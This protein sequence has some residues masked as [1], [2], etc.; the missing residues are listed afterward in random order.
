MRLDLRNGFSYVACCILLAAALAGASRAT[1]EKPE[2]RRLPIREYRDKMKAGWIGQIIGVSWGAP[3]EGRYQQIMPAEKMPPFREELVNDAFGQDDLYVE[4]TFLRSLQ[5]YGLDVSI[6]Q[7]GIDFAN[8]GYPLWVANDAGRRNLRNGIAPPDSSHPKFHNCAG[9]ID[10]QIESDY[11]GLIAP[12]LP[13]VVIALGEKFG[14]LMNYGDGM[15][16]GQFIGAMYAEAFFEKDIH[17]LIESALKAIP[18]Q[19]LYAEM[20]RDMVRWHRENPDRWEKTWEF[21]EKKYNQDRRYNISAL[22]V[23]REGAWV[24]MGLLYGGGDLDKTIIISCRCGFDS[25]CNPSSSGGI[26]FTTRGLAGIPD[27]YYRKLDKKAIFSHTAYNFPALVEATEKLARQA[28]IKAGGRIEKDAQGEEVL[29]IPVKAVAPSKFEDLKHPGP[30]AGSVYTDEEMKEIRSP[31]LQW[32]LPKKFPGWTLQPSQAAGLFYWDREGK[33]DVLELRSQGKKVAPWTLR[34][35]VDV[36]SGKK[37]RLAIAAGVGPGG[38]GWDLTV[39]ADGK[40]LLKRAVD[41]NTA[42]A[43][44]SEVCANLSEFVGKKVNL[45]V[46]GTPRSEKDLCYL[47]NLM[48]TSE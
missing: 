6:R 25:D 32:A 29:L 45:E 3:T 40:T 16:A 41:K 5:Q 38:Q 31:G 44:W 21:A 28:L 33:T 8:S 39:K 37:T 12:G 47:A 1:A 4:M 42:K 23:K 30:I 9:A 26:L 34:R 10:Y 2:F 14:R 18:S 13:D 11:A 46:I 36:P 35:S 48:V 7:A 20:V 17:K 15:Y 43:G 19:C 24:L 22:D 27:R